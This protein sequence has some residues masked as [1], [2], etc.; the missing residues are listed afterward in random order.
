MLSRK[1]GSAEA[2]LARLPPPKV[3]QARA[4]GQGI[5]PVL[6]YRRAVPLGPES[7]RSPGWEASLQGTGE[8]SEAGARG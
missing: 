6:E 8:E 5:T 3:I 1:K 7:V 2:G 4:H